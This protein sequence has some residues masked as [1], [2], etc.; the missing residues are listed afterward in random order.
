MRTGRSGINGLNVF[1]CGLVNL[2][3]FVIVTVYCEQDRKDN[4]IIHLLCETNVS[5]RCDKILIKGEI[6]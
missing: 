3:A 5:I 2:T 1:N 6:F 4:C